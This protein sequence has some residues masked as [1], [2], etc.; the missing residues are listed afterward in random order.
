MTAKK[1]EKVKTVKT[2][3]TPVKELISVQAERL[4]LENPDIARA[5]GYPSPNVISMLKSG[6]MRL[7]INKIARAAAVFKID[8]LYLAMCVDAENDLGLTEILNSVT[9]RTNITLNEE[10][11]IIKMRKI[12]EELDFDMD[13]HQQE[14]TEML[15]AFGRAVVSARRDHTLDV[16]RIKSRVRSALGSEDRKKADEPDADAE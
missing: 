5:L 7:P 10:K 6:A 4:G 11:L 13:D 12:A 3:L 16:T 1:A 2:K 9:K 8:P 15:D 14:L